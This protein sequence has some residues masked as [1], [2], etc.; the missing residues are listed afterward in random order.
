MALI[1]PLIATPKVNQSGTRTQYTISAAEMAAL[2]AFTTGQITL[3]TLPAGVI[4]NW[5]R[6][7]HSVA[8]NI[9]TSLSARLYFNTDLGSGA[10]DVFAAPG[11]TVGTHE[12][13]DVTPRVGLISGTNALLLKFTNGGANMSTITAGS[14]DVWIDFDIAY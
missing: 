13:T 4:L 11:T 1:N 2:G 9:A 6:L 10:L 14:I 8:V 7:K 5:A 3:A 12:I